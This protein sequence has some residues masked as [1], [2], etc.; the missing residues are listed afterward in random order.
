MSRGARFFLLAALACLIGVSSSFAGGAGQT[1]KS[2]SAFPLGT[3]ETI[4]TRQD[5]ARGGF[6][7]DDAHYETLTFSRNGTWR[8]VWFHPRRADQAPAGGHFA[9]KGNVLR[10]LGT[11]DS[12]RWSYSL[13]LLTLRP[14]SVPDAFARF[15][16]TVHPW[17]KIK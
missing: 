6:P 17:R 7:A 15:T 5:V 13:G 8:D 10:L 11:P 12:V 14:V 4:I 3:F 16:Y 1:R 9:V 2:A